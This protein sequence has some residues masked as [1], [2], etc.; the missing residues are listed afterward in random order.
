[1]KMLYSLLIYCIRTHFDYSNKNILW[2]KSK[3]YS[4]SK[5]SVFNHSIFRCKIKIADVNRK[6]QK[7]SHVLCSFKSFNTISS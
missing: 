5:I 1:M 6:T 3:L 4:G 2:F 7:R